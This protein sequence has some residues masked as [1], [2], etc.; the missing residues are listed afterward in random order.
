MAILGSRA[1]MKK[2]CGV[3]IPSQFLI[4]SLVGF[5]VNGLQISQYRFGGVT[6]VPDPANVTLS[7]FV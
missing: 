5:A 6:Q 4:D 3:R 2:V 1:T 7:A